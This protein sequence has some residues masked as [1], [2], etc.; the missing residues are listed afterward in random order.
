MGLI[1]LSYLL[2]FKN[3]FLM[4]YSNEH[5]LLGSVITPLLAAVLV[6]IFRFYNKRAT[7]MI[8]LLGF[9]IPLCIALYL[10][11]QFAN[12]AV[13]TSGYAFIGH[14]TT[15]LEVFGI[16]LM[17]GLNAI[18]MPMYIL[19]GIVGLAAGLYALNAKAKWI[20][21]YWSLLLVMLGGLMGTF[22]SIDVFF[23]YFFHEFALIPTFIMIGIWGGRSSWATAMEVTIYLTIGAMLSLVGLIAIYIKSGAQSFNL[24]D[25]KAHIQEM[26]GFDQHSGEWIFG[27]LLFGFGILV[28]LFPFYS[29]APKAYAAAPASNA[30]LHAGVLKK[31]GL[32]GLIQIG[33]VLLPESFQAWVPLLVYLALGNILILGVSTIA[34]WDLKQMLGYSS[35]MH[36]GYCFLGIATFSVIGVGGAIILM[37]GHGLAVALLFMLATCVHHRTGTYTMDKM[38]GLAKQAPVL[39]FFFV[40]AMFANIGLPG[41]ANFWGEISILVALWQYNPWV[42]VAAAL[43]IVISSVYGLRAIASIFMGAWIE[44]Q[45]SIGYRYR[46]DLTWAEKVPALIL[47]I[48]LLVVGF[49]P[50]CITHNLNEFFK[51]WPLIQSSKSVV[52]HVVSKGEIL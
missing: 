6:A 15:G 32:Y 16:S 35:V 19:A 2:I 24:I 27:L 5:L 21:T 1:L 46:G 51:E 14:W 22:A 26:Q 44:P 28:S 49:Y 10:A 3:L 33:L 36:M 9:T 25:L 52:T 40:A 47:L 50:K 34:Q 38:G 31:F 29:W 7:R 48:A 12:S 45:E 4:L 8:A 17:L 39:G 11:T 20:E 43:G 13:A 42:L 30:M 23:F 37:F 41:F 18:S